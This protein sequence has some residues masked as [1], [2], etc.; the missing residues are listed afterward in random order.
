MYEEGHSI[1]NHSYSHDYKYL[2]KK[3]DNFM[4]ELDATNKILKD[5]LGEDFE[6]NII[7]F[8][9]G[10]FGDKRA[11]FR[12]AVEDKGYTYY[13]WNSLNG[14]AEGKNISKN[15]LVQRFK[16]TS[17]D[18][19]ELIV[20]MH[21]MWAKDTTVEALPEIIEYLQQNDY[22]FNVLE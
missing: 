21:D 20:L 11:S 5:I 9:G 10:S 2:Y 14:D 19:K 15:R 7:R 13:D 4:S 22:K 18:K 8:P 17:R 12:K 3:V 1:G 6:S 16:N